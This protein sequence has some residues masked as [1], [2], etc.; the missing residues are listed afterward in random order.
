MNNLYIYENFTLLFHTALVSEARIGEIL[1][2]QQANKM[3]RG[4]T[5]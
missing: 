4:E 5:K 3:Q 2:N 1:Q